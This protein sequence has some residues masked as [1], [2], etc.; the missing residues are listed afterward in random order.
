MNAPV[1]TRRFPLAS[2]SDIGM[3]TVLLDFFTQPNVQDA[4]PTWSEL[5]K[6]AASLPK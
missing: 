2:Q 3:A 5:V 6:Q 4:E 1:A